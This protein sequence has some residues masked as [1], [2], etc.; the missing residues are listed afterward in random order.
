MNAPSADVIEILTSSTK[1]LDLVLGTNLFQTFMPESPDMCVAVIDSG[2]YD[3]Q[4]N[5][6]Y[7]RPTIQVLVRGTVW[8]HPTAYTHIKQIQ[9]ILHDLHGEVWGG[10]KY[11]GIWAQGDVLQLGYDES[12]RPIL[13][14]N[15]RIHRTNI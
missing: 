14:L 5:Y 7:E 15:F 8:G 1:G 3:S 4:S 13:S 11:I 2:G 12:N 6:I 9:N 10:S